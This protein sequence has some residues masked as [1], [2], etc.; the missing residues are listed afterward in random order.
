MEPFSFL[1]GTHD[2]ALSSWVESANR[3]GTDFPIQNLPFG[4]F[5]L[6]GPNSLTAVGVAIGDSVLDLR[7]CAEAGLLDG[8]SP[9]TVFGCKALSLNRLMG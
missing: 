9:T 2:P 1:D 7:R 8:L 4:V 5:F 6:D 3:P